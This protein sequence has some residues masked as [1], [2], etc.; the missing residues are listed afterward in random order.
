MKHLTTLLTLIASLLITSL[1]PMATPAGENRGHHQSG[2]VGRVQLEQIGW[3]FPWKV[4]VNEENLDP[5]ALLETDEAGYFAINLKPGIYWLTP[6]LSG[7]GAA[8]LVGPRVR[9]M[10]EKKDF[11][12]VELPL[13]FGPYWPPFYVGDGVWVAPM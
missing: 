1:L 9:V 4:R 2:I 6:I 11:A 3:H 7:D 13:V 5:I 10:V 8:T 12:V